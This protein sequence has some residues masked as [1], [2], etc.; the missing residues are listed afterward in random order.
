M[1]FITDCSFFEIL[2]LFIEK[3]PKHIFTLQIL[4]SFTDIG[5]CMFGNNIESL[6]SIYFEHILLN[7]KFCQNILKICKLNFGKIYYYF[8]NLI[9]LK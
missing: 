6:S 9:V 7:E 4:G 3:Y 5:K 1:K 8:V 2:S